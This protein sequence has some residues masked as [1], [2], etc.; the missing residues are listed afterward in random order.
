[1]GRL[2]QSSSAEAMG[3]HASLLAALRRAVFESHARTDPPT[4]K[5]AASGP[6]PTRKSAAS[7][8][9]LAEPARS[10]VAKVR[11]Q[12]YR[13]T[14]GDIEVLA[15]AGL[16]EDEIFEITVAAALGAALRSLDAGLQ[17]LRQEA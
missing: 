15:T 11:D 3:R 9:C 12:S 10:Y 8:G 1:M 6:P 2:R 16:S 5:S 14:D 17:A 4:R 13:I 7:G